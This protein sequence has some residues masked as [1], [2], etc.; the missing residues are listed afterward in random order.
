MPLAQL[1]FSVDWPGLFS[2]SG[3][4]SERESQSATGSE[5]RALPKGGCR[6]SL[7]FEKDAFDCAINVFTSIGY[8][9]E[10]DD[11]RL[12]S[13]ASSVVRKGGFS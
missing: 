10:Q 6:T 5:Q 8:G 4:G 7:T 2:A 12:S 9:S 3:P 1:G 13:G 11:L